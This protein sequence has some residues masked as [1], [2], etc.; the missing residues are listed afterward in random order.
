MNTEVKF[1]RAVTDR[2]CG[3]LVIYYRGSDGKIKV[4]FPMAAIEMYRSRRDEIISAERYTN[5]DRYIALPPDSMIYASEENTRFF[6]DE[7][8]VKEAKKMKAK[9]LEDL[10][11]EAE[12][13]GKL[14]EK[15]EQ[16]E[17]AF[18]AG[19]LSADGRE[20]YELLS[21]YKPY[22]WMVQ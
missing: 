7:M 14:M 6:Y 12:K 13:L 2:K 1:L 5:G 21:E 16:I 4:F 3:D 20:F 19:V 11:K 22:L 17:R 10:P 8:D 15:L 9:L 18:D